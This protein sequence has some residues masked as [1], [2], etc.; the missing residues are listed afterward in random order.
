MT[1]VLSST[2]D[3]LNLAQLLQ[4]A[5]QGED[6]IITE[7]KQPVA[8]LVLLQQAGGTRRVP[9]SAKGLIWIADDFDAPLPE[10]I[11]TEFEA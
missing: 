8:R 1:L 4:R 3:T 7:D 11:L 10:D 2:D 6:I 9:G 5:R